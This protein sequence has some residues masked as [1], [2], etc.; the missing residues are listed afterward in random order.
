MKPFGA[1]AQSSLEQLGSVIRHG[2]LASSQVKHQRCNLMNRAKPNAFERLLCQGLRAFWPRARGT[3]CES[4]DRVCGLLAGECSA[5]ASTHARARLLVQRSQRQGAGLLESESIAS[6]R[7]QIRQCY[8]SQKTKERARDVILSTPLHRMHACDMCLTFPPCACTIYYVQNTPT[9]AGTYAL[10]I[11]FICLCTNIR[12]HVRH[13]RPHPHASIHTCMNVH[14][15]SYTHAGMHVAR[16][17]H[18]VI[19]PDRHHPSCR[20]FLV[21]VRGIGICGAFFAS[22][23][24]SFTFFCF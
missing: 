6:E 11:R 13:I 3:F 4:R 17:P 1:K 12:L 5:A 18:V 22:P 7:A 8:L 16:P 21:G 14:I 10:L 9:Y 19:P 24:L 23:A 15:S 20:L 2:P